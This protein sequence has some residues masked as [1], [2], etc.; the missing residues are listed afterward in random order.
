MSA[1]KIFETFSDLISGMSVFNEKMANDLISSKFQDVA[2]FNIKA[3]SNQLRERYPTYDA[4]LEYA[5]RLSVLHDAFQKAVP[6]TVEEFLLSVVP[7]LTDNLMSSG[8]NDGMGAEEVV[9]L[10]GPKVFAMIRENAEN[11]FQE[12]N[13]LLANSVKAEAKMSAI[14]HGASGGR[15]RADKFAPLKDRVFALA[16]DGSFSSAHHA[17]THI[18]PL[19]LSMPEAKAIGLSSASAVQT[20]GNWIRKEGIQFQVPRNSE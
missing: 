15:K 5:S 16:R 14:R 13:A 1:K 2:E 17:A 6:K 18:A 20:I 12:I 19:I 4:L 10:F 11:N 3:E 8:L 7:Y 9:Q